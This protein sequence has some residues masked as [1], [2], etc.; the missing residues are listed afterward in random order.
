MSR[1]LLEPYTIMVIPR[2]SAQGPNVGVPVVKGAIS[3]ERFN[4]IKRHNKHE[5]II[6]F[7][8]HAEGHHNVAGA[9]PPHCV[10]PPPFSP[11]SRCTELADTKVLQRD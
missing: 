6:H 10:P 5:K 4:A 9:P 7:V 2:L 8:R 3:L 11:H 1:S